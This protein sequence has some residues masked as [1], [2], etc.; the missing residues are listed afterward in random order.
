MKDFPLKHQR[1]FRLMTD[2]L[3]MLYLAEESTLH[4]FICLFMDRC[5][6]NSLHCKIRLICMFLTVSGFMQLQ[7]ICER[8]WDIYYSEI[9]LCEN[10]CTS[11]QRLKG[12]ESQVAHF[13][14]KT[15]VKF[16]EHS[17]VSKSD[18]LSSVGCRQRK[19]FPCTPLSNYLI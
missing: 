8:A 9:R 3:T 14:L 12:S 1:N 19:A 4:L 13:A 10:A 6:L 5:S 7:S 15:D 11:P 17:M 18:P 2:T 16:C